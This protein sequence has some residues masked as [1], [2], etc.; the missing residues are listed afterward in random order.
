[1]TIKLNDDDVMP[2]GKYKGQRLGEIEDS[3]FLWFLKQ[4]WSS[5]FPDLVEYAQLVEE[6]E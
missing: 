6:D 1:M 5:K 2:F 3:Y 4:E